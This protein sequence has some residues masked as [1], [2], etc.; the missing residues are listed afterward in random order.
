MTTL[1]KYPFTAVVLALILAAAC[2]AVANSPPPQTQSGE[3]VGAYTGRAGE[4]HAIDDNK[5]GVT[6]YLT[7]YYGNSVLSCVKR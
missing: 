3:L 1:K 5:R 6:C 2:G 4:L 7:H